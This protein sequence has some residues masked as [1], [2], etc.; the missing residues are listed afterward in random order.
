MTDGFRD[1]DSPGRCDGLPRGP[2]TRGRALAA[3][4]RRVGDRRC[5]A[6]CRR[7]RS[8]VPAR[9]A[10]RRAHVRRHP[11]GPRAGARAA[12]RASC[13]R[14]VRLSSRTRT[15]RSHARSTPHE[16]L[17]PGAAAGE[18]PAGTAPTVRRWLVVEVGG[19]WGRDAVPD[20]ELPRSR[21]SQ[22][23]GLAFGGAGVGCGPL[24]PLLSGGA[25][26]RRSCGSPAPSTTEASCDGSR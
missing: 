19:A 26:L 3:L 25:D 17:Q 10:G 16:L 15:R 7:R 22:A 8:P 21:A 12:R 24:R 2:R 20:T 14:T 9:V 13:S 5:P 11:R 18:A 6:R 23:R 1:G 4:A